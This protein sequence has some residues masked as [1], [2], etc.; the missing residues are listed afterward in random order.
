MSDPVTIPG[1]LYVFLV[2]WGMLGSIAMGA[3]VLMWRNIRE[4]DV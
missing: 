1:G 4:H 3:C 2:A